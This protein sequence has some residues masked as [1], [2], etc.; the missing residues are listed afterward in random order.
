MGDWFAHASCEVRV[1]L[2]LT[3]HGPRNAVSRSVDDMQS[4]R[5]TTTGE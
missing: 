2:I 4:K 5:L 3:T 1:L